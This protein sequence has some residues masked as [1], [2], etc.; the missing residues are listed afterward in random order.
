MNYEPRYIRVCSNV[1]GDSA[2][3]QTDLLSPYGA[4]E[5]A[6]GDLFEQYKDKDVT[7]VRRHIDLLLTLFESQME[8]ANK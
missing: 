6:L 4:I 8:E 7:F 5:R 1:S 2:I 3:V